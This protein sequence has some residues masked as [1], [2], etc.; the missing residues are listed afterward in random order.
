LPDSLI[1][2]KKLQKITFP[3]QQNQYH[4]PANTSPVPMYISLHSS[5]QNGMHSQPGERFYNPCSATSQ[6]S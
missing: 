1:Q 4:C 3:V 5:N 2:Q 6:N